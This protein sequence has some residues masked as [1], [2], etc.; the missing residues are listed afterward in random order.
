M[1]VR[2]TSESPDQ[3]NIELVLAT[4]QL[5]FWLVAD[6]GSFMPPSA[7]LLEE[8][9]FF[10]RLTLYGPFATMAVHSEG[11]AA[12]VIYTGLVIALIATALRWPHRTIA[13]C[14]GVG[15][16]ALWFLVGFAVAGLHIT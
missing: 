4:L 3:G 9:L 2:W 1:R 8:R 10:A 13:L 16:V 5:V 11:P 7:G 12:A 14:A 6:F 15:G